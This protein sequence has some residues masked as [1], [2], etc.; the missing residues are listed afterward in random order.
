[1]FVMLCYVW[2]VVWNVCIL[3]LVMFVMCVMLC[4]VM[5]CYV[6]KAGRKKEA[7]HVFRVMFSVNHWR[8][9]KTFPVRNEFTHFGC[10][11]LDRFSHFSL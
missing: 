4:Y 10:V 5:L 7:L 9:S 6:C 1:M 2:N 8:S 3:M 11:N